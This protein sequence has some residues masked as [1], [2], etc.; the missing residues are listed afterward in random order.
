[1]LA[2]IF[3]V[4]AMLTLAVVVAVR[5]RLGGIARYLSAGLLTLTIVVAVWQRLGGMAR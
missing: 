4:L 2:G 3:V 1:M 5:R